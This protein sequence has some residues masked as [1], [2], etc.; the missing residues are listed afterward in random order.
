M[1]YGLAAARPIRP[2]D[3]TQPAM[4]T[5]HRRPRIA[6]LLSALIAGGTV[7][8]IAASDR[9]RALWHTLGQ[10]QPVWLLAALAAEL[11]AYAG[12][13][14]AYRS[15]I[16]APGRPRLSLTL[17]ARLVVA[18]FGPFVPLGGFAFDRLALRAVHYSRRLARI[19]VLGLG[20]IEYLLLAPAAC[21]CALILLLGSG[22]ASPWLTLPWVFAV[23]PGFVLAW[24]ATRPQILAYF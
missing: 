10:M 8:A 16:L 11:V 17:T 13:I 5:L 20:V 22:R 7:T 15:T 12:Y 18:G 6:M 3:G 21:V 23:P 9:P 24:W 2:N 19:Q 1:T 4:K 14:V